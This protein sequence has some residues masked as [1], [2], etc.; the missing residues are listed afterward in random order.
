MHLSFRCHFGSSLMAASRF[1]ALER[2]RGDVEH[3]VRWRQPTSRSFAP[4][5]IGRYARVHLRGAA[6]VRFFLRMRALE[7]WRRAVQCLQTRWWQTAMWLLLAANCNG[8]MV[9]G[10]LQ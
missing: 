10:R 8:S 5:D 7:N 9:A 1:F 6:W 3:H 2:A 4:L